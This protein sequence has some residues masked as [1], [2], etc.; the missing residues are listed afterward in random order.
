S[1]LTPSARIGSIASLNVALSLVQPAYP[2]MTLFRE[3]P[4]LVRPTAMSPHSSGVAIM[5]WVWRNRNFLVGTSYSS[6]TLQLTGRLVLK[7]PRHNK[8]SSRI[9]GVG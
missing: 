8:R 1:H 2:I 3:T 7:R 6:P 9:F 4:S 5:T